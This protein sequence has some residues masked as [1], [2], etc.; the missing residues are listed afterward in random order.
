[1]VLNKGHDTAKSTTAIGKQGESATRNDEVGIPIKTA[2]SLT[3]ENTVLTGREFD[4]CSPSHSD[5][6]VEPVITQYAVC[7]RQIMVP[8]AAVEEA[9]S[10]SRVRAEVLAVRHI[11]RCRN[12]WYKPVH[13]NGC[14]V[15]DCDRRVCKRSGQ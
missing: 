14:P 8:Q 9:R 1:M 5:G 13:V 15:Q 6:E 11:M 10:M 2:L 7:V 3:R 12:Q 4:G